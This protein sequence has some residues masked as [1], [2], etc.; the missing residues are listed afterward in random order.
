VVAAREARARDIIQKVECHLKPNFE[1][2]LRRVDRHHPHQPT[3][4]TKFENQSMITH[5]DDPYEWTTE[6]HDYRFWSNFQVNW[7]L[8]VIKDRKNPVT[9]R[10]YVDWSYMQ[11]K[12]DLVFNM[13]IFDILGLYQDWNTELVTQFYSTTWW[14]GNGYESTINFSI[15]GHRFSLCVTKFP[16]IFGLAPN[17]LHRP[18]VIT[19]RTIVENELASL[20]MTRNDINY[21]TTH[22]LLH[23][24]TM[25]NNIL[26]NT[27]TPKRGDRTKIWGS[28]RNLLLAILDDH[29]PLCFSTFLW[30]EMM[31]MLNHGAQYVIYA[32]Y[33]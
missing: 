30:T 31:H 8:S 11:Q 4:Y 28:T 19:E 32:P 22:G 2:T 21:D 3:D 18:K 26:C 27:H 1:Y 33:I 16:T 9:P 23:E 5:N 6:L 12:R 13:V 20:Y 17:D 7:Y 24:Y 15:E 29:P 14:S 10:M 25:F